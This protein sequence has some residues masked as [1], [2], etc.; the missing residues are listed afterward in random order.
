MVTKLNLSVFFFIML[1]T[2]M[3][4]RSVIGDNHNTGHL[5]ESECGSCHLVTG[6]INAENAGKLIGSQEHLCTS[7]HVNAVEVS[8]PSGF[9]PSR[10]IPNEYPLDWKHDMTCS[11]CHKVHS[12]DRGLM[13]VPLYGKAHCLACH[14]DDFFDNMIDGGQSLVLSGHMAL[15]GSYEEIGLDTFSINCMTCH[16]DQSNDNLNVAISTNAVVRHASGKSNHPV[17]V[18]Y[19]KA[20]EYGGFRDASLLNQNI[21]L[22]DGKVSCV[23]CHEGYSEQ[24]GAIV[25]SMNGSSLCLQ[26]HDK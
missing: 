17:G 6:E 20:F 4:Y 16:E 25:V 12:S 11:T 19:Q 13:R 3:Y 1:A 18:S 5:M 21:Q 9:S 10:G 14:T 26:C 23:S 24:H 22:P 15:P 2:S 8:H 7:C